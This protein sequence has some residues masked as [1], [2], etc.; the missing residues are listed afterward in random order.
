LIGIAVLVAA[1]GASVVTIPAGASVSRAAASKITVAYVTGDQGDPY[2]IT[3]RC[4]ATAQAASMGATL[5]WFGTASTSAA[6]EFSLFS[7]AAVTNPSALV[8]AP[9]SNTGF[10]ASVAAQM[11]KGVPVAL[12]GGILTP[13]A[14]YQVVESNYV[15][16]G[17]LLASVI[18]KITG[19]TGSMAII[20]QSTGNP[21]DADRY[22][23]LEGILKAKYPHLKILSLQYGAASTATSATIAAALILVNPDLK[24]I[25]ATNGPQAIG[26]ASA[27]AAAKAGARVKLVSFDSTP[28][29]VNL[30]KE[31]RL[32]ATVAQSP[33]YTAALGVK[34]VVSYLKS[35]PTLGP[36]KPSSAGVIHTP[37]QLLTAANINTPLAKKFEYVTSCSVFK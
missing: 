21:P 5:K 33:Y 25:Y 19:G 4:G 26:T 9:F 35:H 10:S 15:A 8:L 7:S 27:I 22:V 32:A 34:S 13:A 3:E 17:E 2:F 1:I 14:G 29:Q 31:G 30:I 18:G 28:D 24:V 20:A 37:L 36:V 11:K 23:G 16:G 12:T 6:N